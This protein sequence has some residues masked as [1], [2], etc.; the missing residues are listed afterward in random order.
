MSTANIESFL[1]KCKI[2]AKFNFYLEFTEKNK[3]TLLEL[4]YTKEDVYNVLVELE[5]RD[6][7]EGPV[8]DKQGF[9]KDFWVFGKTIQ[10]REV[11]I[12]IKVKDLNFEGDKQLTCYCISFHFAEFPLKYPNK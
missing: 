5:S 11:Y 7:I 9:A 1:T 4:D 3:T 10:G 12:K 6:Y 8:L 2:A